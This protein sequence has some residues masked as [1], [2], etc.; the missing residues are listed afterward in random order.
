MGLRWVEARAEQCLRESMNGVVCKNWS[1]K[2]KEWCTL[3]LGQGQAMPSID[4]FRSRTSLAID[5]YNDG[6]ATSSRRPSPASFLVALFYNANPIP[7]S[8]SGYLCLSFQIPRSSSGYLCLTST[9]S[10]PASRYLYLC[11]F[12]HNFKSTRAVLV[13]QCHIQHQS[14][15]E[16]EEPGLLQA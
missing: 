1:Y 14:L 9:I 10:N 11:L 5:N 13:P 4:H 7:N 6:N 12:S 15:E 8:T 16:E 2:I 3:S